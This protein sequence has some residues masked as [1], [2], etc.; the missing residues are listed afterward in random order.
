MC[1]IVN[2]EPILYKLPA[3]II[4]NIDLMIIKNLYNDLSENQ[5]NLNLN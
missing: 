5:F 4:E 3:R 1:G 2:A